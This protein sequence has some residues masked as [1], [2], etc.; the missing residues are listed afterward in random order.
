MSFMIEDVR[1]AFRELSKISFVPYT[2]SDVL[3]RPMADFSDE[4]N[5]WQKFQL[6]LNDHDILLEEK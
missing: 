4:L 5:I 2:E 1:S 3:F 6:D